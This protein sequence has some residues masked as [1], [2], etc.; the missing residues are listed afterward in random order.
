MEKN[1]FQQKVKVHTQKKG[2][3][4]SSWEDKVISCKHLAQ[5]WGI[6]ASKLV[7]AVA[8]THTD[9]CDV[10]ITPIVAIVDGQEFIS[11]TQGEVKNIKRNQKLYSACVSYNKSDDTFLFKSC[12]G[13]TAIIKSQILQ[14]NF[15][16]S[17]VTCL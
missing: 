15:G 10:V 12:T 7:F 8:E 17:V 4:R 16:K 13:A 2:T 9:D 5:F 1:K 6:S 14:E 11:L 3:L